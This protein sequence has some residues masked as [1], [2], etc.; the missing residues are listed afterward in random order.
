MNTITRRFG[1]PFTRLTLLA[2]LLLALSLAQ[3]SAASAAINSK[4]EPA[5]AQ[6]LI[7]AVDNAGKGKSQIYTIDTNSLAVAAHG[8]QAN[9]D[10]EDVAISVLNHNLFAS[11][12]DEVSKDKG[13]IYRVD[14]IT[15]ALKLLGAS[16]FDRITIMKFRATDDTLWGW[17]DG[18]GLVQLDQNTG[19]GTLVFKSSKKFEGMAFQP[20]GKLYLATDEK[21]YVLDLAAKSLTKFA[22]NLPEDT[23][24]LASL[25]NGVLLGGFSANSKPNLFI[26][27]IAT[28]QVD[29]TSKLATSFKS[30]VGLCVPA[31]LGV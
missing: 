24:S 13:N 28:K 9:H 25:G 1:R 2:M 19:K 27:N 7:Y 31:G 18:K 23:Q 16:G 20:D 30:I 14:G 26:Y 17:A 21:L 29:A 4:S 5:P 11:T 22:S 12:G 3:V 6:N 15:G 8:P 10:F